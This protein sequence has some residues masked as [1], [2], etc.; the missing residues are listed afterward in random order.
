MNKT[1]KLTQ[2]AM[3]LAIIG[4]LMAIDRQLSF[5]FTDFIVMMVPTVL[6][7]YSTMHSLKDGLILCVGLGALTILFGSVT[8]Y[9][10][11]PVCCLVGIGVSYAIAKNLDRRRITLVAIALYT[12]GEVIIT[13]VVTP[14][15]GI[16]LAE[17][18][19]ELSVML[20]EYGLLSQL[21]TLGLTGSITSFLIVMYVASVI[22][23]GIMEGY[24]TSLLSTLLLKRLKIKNI[25]L[26]NVLDLRISPVLT[27]ILFALTAI[28]YFI[29]KLLFIQEYSEILFYCLICA[30]TMS[31]LVLAYYGYLF[32]VILGRLTNGKKGSLLLILG[33]IFLFPASFLALIIVGFL[34]GS[35]PLRNYLERRIADIAD[36]NNNNIQQ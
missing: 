1:K 32:L 24:I 6:V 11:M 10:Y 27:Y 23:I 22:I 21:E 7:I 17:Q 36:R 34:Y 18:I 33:I 5:F 8:T 2:G 16:N 20:E 14:L 29:P 25:G 12:I 31:S 28:A 13:F 4:A 3:L 15:I 35:G 30:S 26:N 9:T 19:E